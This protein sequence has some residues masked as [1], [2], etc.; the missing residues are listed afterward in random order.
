M[1]YK[2]PGDEATVWGKGILG[3]EVDNRLVKLVEENDDSICARAILLGFHESLAK[4]I[5]SMSPQVQEHILSAIRHAIEESRRASDS[6]K[7]SH[8]SLVGCTLREWA[9]EVDERVAYHVDR[10]S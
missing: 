1:E 8:R 10:L 6:C 5:A 2:I 4:A 9:S 7:S 3:W